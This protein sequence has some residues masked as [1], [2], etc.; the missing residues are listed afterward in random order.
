MTDSATRAAVAVLIVRFMCS[1]NT[2]RASIGSRRVV[3]TCQVSGQY[4]LPD[5]AGI[6]TMLVLALDGGN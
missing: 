1:P 4:A 3:R 6:A 5:R 2:R